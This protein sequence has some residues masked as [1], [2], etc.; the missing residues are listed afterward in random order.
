MESS[1]SSLFA[2]S[3]ACKASFSEVCR[4]TLSS[5]GF[6]SHRG[7]LDSCTQEGGSPARLLSRSSPVASL[8]EGV[9]SLQGRKAVFCDKPKCSET[10]LTEAFGMVDQSFFFV[11]GGRISMHLDRRKLL[12]VLGMNIGLEA[13]KTIDRCMQKSI[14][15]DQADIREVGGW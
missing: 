14:N 8:W 15:G 2:A 9:I 6:T 13:A 11:L 10:P 5:Y 7:S 12:G 4:R 1:A 3:W